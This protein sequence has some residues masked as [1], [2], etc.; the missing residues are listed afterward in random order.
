M[1]SFPAVP[2]IQNGQSVDQGVTNS[3]IQALEERTNWL[4]D[5][6]TAITAGGQLTI[7][8]LPI[9]AGVIAGTPVYLDSSTNT[10][11]KALSSV[12]GANLQ[13]ISDQSRWV[14]IVISVSGGFG[15]LAIGGR[16]TLTT[17]AWA[18]S[19]Q[20]GVFSAGAL[21]ISRDVAG[22]FV[23]TAGALSVYVGS[24]DSNGNLYMRLGAQ[25]PFLEHGHYE[26]ELQAIP[27][28]TTA[29][30]V[31]PNPHVVT[32]NPALPGWLN[33]NLTNF[34]GATIPGGAA[35]G[36]NINHSSESA[37]REIFPPSPTNN[38]TFVQSGLVLDSARIVV[39]TSGIWWMSAAY[40]QAPW[41]VNYVASPVNNKIR[42]WTSRIIAETD[43]TSSVEA[44]VM[45]S[46]ANGGLASIGV[47]RVKSGSIDDL[48][49]TGSSGDNTAGFKGIITLTNKGVTVIKGERGL[50]L[51]GVASTSGVK[52]QVVA[53]LNLALPMTWLGS[54]YTAPQTTDRLNFATTISAGTLISNLKCLA[55]GPG[56]SDS[57]DFHI[58]A[59]SDL[60]SGVSYNL[61]LNFIVGADTTIGTST[62]RTF[63]VDFYRYAILDGMTTARLV[64]TTNGSVNEGTP[65]IV[66]TT[67]VSGG[68]LTLTST[69]GAIIRL[70]NGT[71]PLGKLRV[72]EATYTLIKP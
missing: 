58:P 10:L 65:G 29:D 41:P 26:R 6:I 11:R 64:L 9:E 40:G 59:Q 48:E 55:L 47:T 43:L 50:T 66:Q 72:I 56:A 39:N 37:L 22:K 67:T 17:T 60:P 8:G 23:T 14:G 51:T 18:S 21:Y 54:S 53:N 12:N 4:R 19:Y 33:A 24:M 49:V 68:S 25:G 44:A 28:G 27:A 34:P 45:A 30:P 71:L 1:A 31:N 13:Q 3:P 62:P 35:F 15:T 2:P 70:R 61:I 63:L 69:Q 36:Y 32:D 38:A 5:A 42:L 57:I 16:V 7:S 46:L 52:G 20:S